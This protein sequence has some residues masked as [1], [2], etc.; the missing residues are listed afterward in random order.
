MQPADTLIRKSSLGV[1]FIELVISL[2]FLIPLLLLTIEFSHALYE[3]QTI[4]KQVRAGARYLTTQPL[5]VSG[6]AEGQ[7]PY[8]VK[9]SCLIRIS[10]LN[11]NDVT[12]KPVL[13]K[14]NTSMIKINDSQVGSTQEKLYAQPTDPGQADSTTINLVKVSVVGYLHQFLKGMPEIEFPAITVIMR[15]SS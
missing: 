7:Q 12:A 14:L 9:A 1:A 13:T 6:V 15:Q 3:Y 11:C 8:W 10:T 2:I 5:A 4:V